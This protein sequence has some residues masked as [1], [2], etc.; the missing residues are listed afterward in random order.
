MSDNEVSLAIGALAMAPSDHNRLYAGTGEGNIFFLVHSRPLDAA[1][2]DYHG[3]GVLRSSDGGDTWTHVGCADLCWC[4]VLPHRGASD[5]SRCA[6]RRDHGHGLMRS[7]DGGATWTAI[8]SGLP[9]LSARVIACT[10]V[11]YDPINANRAWCAFWGSG[12]Y[13]TDNANATTP[14]WTKLITGLPARGFRPHRACRGALQPRRDIRIDRGHPCRQGTPKRRVREHQCRR[15]LVRHPVV[16]PDC[17][18]SYTLNIAVDVSTP[19]VLYVSGFELYKC[20]QSG[21]AWT[22]TNVGTRIHVDNHA[23]ASHPTNYLLIYAG[24]DGGIYRVGR[25]RLHLGRQDQRGTGHYPVRV[26]QPASLVGCAR[27]S[28]EPRITGPRCSATASSFTT[29]RT[30]MAARPAS[31]PKIPTT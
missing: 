4:R 12:I 5:K 26:H 19:N 1:N 24:T 14:T 6:I 8:T 23:F 21:G 31:I 16:V 30:S 7:Q 3:V 11:A 17:L 28:A 18:G 2:E 29:R 10:D 15:H 13:R 25:R 22:V 20:V 9:A 27:S